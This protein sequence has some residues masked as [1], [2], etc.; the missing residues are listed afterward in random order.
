MVIL[1]G[2]VF[3]VSEVPL[4]LQ[5]RSSCVRPLIGSLHLLLDR[6]ILGRR[7][8]DPVAAREISSGRVCV[9]DTH[10]Q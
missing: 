2:W 4:Y 3:L 7:R 5:G 1:W 8:L 6:G 9:M 10:A